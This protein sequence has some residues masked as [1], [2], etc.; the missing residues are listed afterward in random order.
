MG[1]LTKART[2]ANA[3]YNLKTYTKIGVD[4]PKETASAFREKCERT[5]IKQ[6]QILL[7][8]IEDFLR[9]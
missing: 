9:E 4:V 8:A 1:K 7:K 6:R 2:E 5:G 3:R